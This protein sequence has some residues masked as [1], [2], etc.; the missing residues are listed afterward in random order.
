[1]HEL[2]VP[3]DKYY[4]KIMAYIFPRRPEL[5]FAK[6]YTA[7]DRRRMEEMYD[8][9]RNDTLCSREVIQIAVGC[10]LRVVSWAEMLQDRELA[11]RRQVAFTNATVARVNA[12]AHSA[13]GLPEDWQIGDE[14]VGSNYARVAGKRKINSNKRYTVTAITPTHLTVAGLDGIERTMTL[15]SSRDLLWR[16]WCCTGHSIQGQTLGKAS[17]SMTSTDSS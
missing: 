8:Q 1:M 2:A 12:W 10:E 11:L 3:F 17:A 14:V 7:D 5:K 9:L 15:R 13:G 4:D 6:R 16:P